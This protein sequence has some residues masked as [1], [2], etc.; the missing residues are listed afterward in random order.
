MSFKCGMGGKYKCRVYC[1][2]VFGIL[3]FAGSNQ[4]RYNQIYN[5]ATIFHLTR[6]E[7]LIVICLIF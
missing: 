4:V 5:W 7:V 6:F 2:G 1:L 3:M